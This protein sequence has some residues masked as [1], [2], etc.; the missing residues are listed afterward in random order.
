MFLRQPGPSI[1]TPWNPRFEVCFGTCGLRFP[2]QAWGH[3]RRTALEHPCTE[4]FEVRRNKP[5]S[6]DW[7]RADATQQLLQLF[8]ISRL[9]PLGYRWPGLSDTLGLS[10]KR[11]SLTCMLER[12]NWKRNRSNSN[13]FSVWKKLHQ[14]GTKRINHCDWYRTSCHIKLRL[15]HCFLWL[16]D[17]NLK[18]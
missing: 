2:G 3:R 1:K 5:G 4:G 9:E 15:N 8:K 6:H 10:I 14:I 13:T 12:L 16:I 18:L 17:L 11:Y 7:F